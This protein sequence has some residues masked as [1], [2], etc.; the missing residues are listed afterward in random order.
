MSNSFKCS[1]CHHW[2]EWTVDSHVCAKK[3]TEDVAK[4]PDDLNS[5]DNFVSN[6]Q[7][8]NRSRVSHFIH[9]FGKTYGDVVREKESLRDEVLALRKGYQ[10]DQ[11]CE[12]YEGITE[13]NRIRDEREGK[14]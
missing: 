13:A 12:F 10:A 6:W 2:F 9:E 1:Y 5:W 3:P 14:K 8:W 7:D 4:M 11:D